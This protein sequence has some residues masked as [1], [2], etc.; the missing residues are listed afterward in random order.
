MRLLALQLSEGI[1]DVD[2]LHL[3][4]MKLSGCQGAKQA[5]SHHVRE[6]LPLARPDLGEVALVAAQDVS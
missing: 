1:A 5:L 4:G 6:V 2:A 3:G